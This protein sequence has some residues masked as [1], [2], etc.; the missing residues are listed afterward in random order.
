MVISEVLAIL[1]VFIGYWGWYGLRLY[2]LVLFYIL[3]L[4]VLPPLGVIGFII[5][6]A[7]SKERKEAKQQKLLKKQD[8]E[9]NAINYVLKLPSMYDQISLS[10]ISKETSI[11]KG[12]IKKKV[13]EFLFNGKL[14]G[15]LRGDQLIFRE[16]ESTPSQTQSQQVIVQQ[17]APLQ[18]GMKFCLHCGAQIRS[19]ATFC[20]KCGKP[21]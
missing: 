12:E 19:T 6:L 21:Q 3:G 9:I 18:E 7:V 14:E 8:R 10:D 20:D 1:F 17:V 5:T 16:K 4:Y 11:T 13:E 2:G 15:K